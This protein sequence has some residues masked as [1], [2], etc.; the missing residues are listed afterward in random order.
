MQYKQQECALINAN[1]PH[2]MQHVIVIRLR[3]PNQRDLIFT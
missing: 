2:H 3:Y 1:I